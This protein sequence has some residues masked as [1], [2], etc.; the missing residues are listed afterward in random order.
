MPRANAP[1]N[2]AEELPFE[3]PNFFRLRVC[4]A[5]LSG[6]PIVVSAIREDEDNPGIRDCESKLLSLIEKI[7][8]GTKIEINSTGTRVTLRPG[9][10]TGGCVTLN[11]GNDRCL[12]YFLEPLILISPFCKQA[13]RIKLLGVT[14][15]PNELSVDQIKTG[16]LNV[17]NRFILNDEA[18][19]LKIERRGL[20]PGGGGVV[21]FSAPVVRNLRP[22]IREKPGKVCKIRGQAFVTKVSPSLAHRAIDAAK[23]TLRDYISDVY[24]TVDQRKGDA[25]G[26]SPGYGL[27]LY[28]ETTE[29]VFYT[30]EA[31]SRP[32]GENGDPIVP[33]DVGTAAGVALLEEI[34]RGGCC[35]SSSQVLASTF[36]A[37]GEKDVSKF[38]MGPL[39]TYTIHSLR[40]LQQFFLT[41]F[42]IDD[43]AALD[44]GKK[45]LE[46]DMRIGDPHKALLTGVGVGFKNLNKIII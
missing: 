27:F 31:I 33:E 1:N 21:I 15:A 38:L 4:Y 25:G 37:L 8:N 14:N 20:K 24:I 19:D 6:R 29:G 26:N 28:A 34:A 18:L 42:K 9:M 2:V 41:T 30:A 5:V 12:S 45:A 10:I 36:M 3:G 32:K 16:W 7:T 43:F 44:A 40:H 22:L 13:M 11:C 17:Y 39:S 35:D 46:A 23:K